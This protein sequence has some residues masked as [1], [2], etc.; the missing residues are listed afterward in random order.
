MKQENMNDTND[1]YEGLLGLDKLPKELKALNMVICFILA[2]SL[3]LVNY[4]RIVNTLDQMP[5]RSLLN[6]LAWISPTCIAAAWL[7]LTGVQWRRALLLFIFVPV[8]T[9]GILFVIF[10]LAI[11]FMS[12]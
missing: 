1:T 6:W 5:L 12:D 11:L 7:R 2:T 3:A 8:A 9:L 10:I 4:S